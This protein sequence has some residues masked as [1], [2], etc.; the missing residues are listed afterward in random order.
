MTPQELRAARKRLG[1]TQQELASKLAMSRESINKMEADKKPIMPRT[2]M[3]VQALEKEEGRTM[4]RTI[5]E[6]RVNAP[7]LENGVTIDRLVIK[8]SPNGD[9]YYVTG[10]NLGLRNEFQSLKEVGAFIRANAEIPQVSDQL[11]P[12]LGLPRRLVRWYE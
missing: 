8:L 11:D 12:D 5:G 10:S 3:L 7:K 6:I 1:L 9:S 2:A 4:Y